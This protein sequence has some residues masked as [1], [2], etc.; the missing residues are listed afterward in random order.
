LDARLTILLCK[1]ITVA[2]PKELKT[3]LNLAEFYEEGCGSKSA[4]LPKM[5]MMMM[6]NLV[7]NKMYLHLLMI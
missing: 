4:V 7:V 5:M 1:H 6:M 3:E 2:K